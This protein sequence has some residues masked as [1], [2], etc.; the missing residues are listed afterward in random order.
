VK[1][2]TAKD[3]R[4]LIETPFLKVPIGGEFWNAGG[5]KY[6]VRMCK[7]GEHECVSLTGQFKGLPGTYS[8][9]SLVW[10]ILG[11]EKTM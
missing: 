10:F 1:K 2:K 6:G 4:G 3:L 7:T 5:P 8:P 11:S 9:S